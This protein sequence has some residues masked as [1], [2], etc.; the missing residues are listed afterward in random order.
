MNS[1]KP[2]KINKKKKDDEIITFEDWYLIDFAY[3]K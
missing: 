3:I 2:I 1:R